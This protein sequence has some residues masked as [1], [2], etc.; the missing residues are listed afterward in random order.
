MN[1]AQWHAPPDIDGSSSSDVP[2]VS[3]V[4][5]IIMPTTYGLLGVTTIIEAGQMLFSML[6]FYGLCND[7]TRLVHTYGC[8]LRPLLTSLSDV[9][10]RWMDK[11]SNPQEMISRA[12]KTPLSKSEQFFQASSLQHL[13]LRFHAHK[14]MLPV[15]PAR[16]VR[17]APCLSK[18]IPICAIARQREKHV[19]KLFSNFKF[20]VVCSQFYK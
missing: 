9:Q 13:R 7:P 2:L 15:L 19:S 11:F 17:R 12:T 8:S 6:Q 20:V 3:S 5:L 14:P 1:A 18:I 10:V 4:V 16:N